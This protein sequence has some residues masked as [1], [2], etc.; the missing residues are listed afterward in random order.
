MVNQLDEMVKLNAGLVEE[1]R[2]SAEAAKRR[3]EED[4]QAQEAARQEAAKKKCAEEAA[5][6]ER[7]RQLEAETA[8]AAAQKMLDDS[9]AALSEKR[10]GALKEHLLPRT[11][12]L[13]E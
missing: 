12:S 8:R 1:A 6:A 2:L 9:A 4:R 13:S 5:A 11:Y 10:C 3:A 7:Q